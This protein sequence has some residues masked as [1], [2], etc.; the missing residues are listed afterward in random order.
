MV[1][2]VGLR[3]EIVTGRDPV[4]SSPV[5]AIILETDVD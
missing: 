2:G 5:T 4:H 3:M 1:G